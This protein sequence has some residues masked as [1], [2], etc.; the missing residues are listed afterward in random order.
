[1]AQMNLL[2]EHRLT[3]VEN[4]L[5]AAKGEEG[6]RGMDGE[7]GLNRCQLFHLE[8]VSNA[9]LLTAQGTLSSLLG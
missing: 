6:G 3:D 9:V 2:T 4:R 7:L 1:M 5:V 8:W